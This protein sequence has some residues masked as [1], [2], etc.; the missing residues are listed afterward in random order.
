[1]RGSYLFN[2]GGRTDTPVQPGKYAAFAMSLRDRAVS[3]G[4]AA[5]IEASRCTVSPSR[6]VMIDAAQ[7]T[8]IVRVSNHPHGKRSG[9]LNPH[10]DIVTHDGDTGLDVALAIIDRIA[11]GDIAWFDAGRSRLA[12]KRRK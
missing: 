9:Q 4:L 10:I 11:S 7:R 5:Y 8:W 12:R 1:M 3:H 2:A 6:Y